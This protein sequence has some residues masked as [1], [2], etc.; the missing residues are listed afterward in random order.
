MPT[1]KRVASAFL[2]IVRLF[3]LAALGA[4]SGCASWDRLNPLHLSW[5]GETDTVVLGRNRQYVVVIAAQGDTLES[6]AERFLGDRSRSWIIAD[7]NGMDRLEPGMEVV[8]PLQ[9]DNRAGIYLDGYQTVPI[10]TYHRFGPRRDR[11]T[12]TAKAFDAQMRY[13]RDHDYRVIPLRDVVGFLQGTV[14]LPQRAVVLT[15]D[16]GY[17]SAYEVA[18]PIL[19]RYGFPATVMV[20][21]DY[22]GRGGLTWPQIEEMTASHL[23]SIQAHS[24][25]HR[26]LT[27]RDPRIS[28]ADYAAILRE[29]IARP[30]EVLKRRLA[31]PS[32]AYAYPY[33]DFSQPVIAALERAGYAIGLTVVA[34]ENPAF[35]PP[36][37]LRRTMILG[38]RDMAAF[39]A[40]LQTFAS[41]AHK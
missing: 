7:E 15:I 16:D 29:E 24:K 31:E 12:V 35:A 23:V 9:D 34:G 1:G 6:L 32:F 30:R 37:M 18:Y 14:R 19:K 17:A 28:D 13:L 38:G 22:I 20:Y 2:L 3:V 40:A 8:I 21:T 25:T 27:A 10:L 5:S 39:V 26:N 4:A 11:L 33:G 41:V 36:Y